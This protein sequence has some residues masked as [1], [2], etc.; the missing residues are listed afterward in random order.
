MVVC[1]F[2]RKGS[3][4]YMPNVDV[5][6][7]FGMAVRRARLD[8]KFSEGFN[9]HMQLFFSGP[10]PI[11]MESECEYFS[12]VCGES[13]EVFMAR[14]NAT[15]PENLRIVKAGSAEKANV[16]ALAKAA[17]YEITLRGGDGERAVAGIMEKEA[18]VIAYTDKGKLVEK[19]VRRLIYSLQGQGNKIYAVLSY[20]NSNLRAERLVT[21]LL[22]FSA[23]PRYDMD[24]L[25][26]MMYTCTDEGLVDLDEI[27]FNKG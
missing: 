13:P 5:I 3:A 26:K 20:G 22:K 18:L 9:P 19:E 7:F 14:M 10:P 11:G 15:L 4:S 12:A 23:Q 25:K 16:A 2:L 8:V 17:A 6:R 21:N 1:K 27:L 24:I